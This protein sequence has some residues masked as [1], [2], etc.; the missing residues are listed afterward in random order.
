MAGVTEEQAME[1][2]A[3]QSIYLDDITLHDGARH[4]E[5]RLAGGSDNV[6]SSK[7]ALVLEVRVPADY[8]GVVPE[9]QVRSVKGVSNRTALELQLKLRD[10]AQ[11]S[12][13]APMVF[14]LTQMLKDWLEEHLD[15]EDDSA[16]SAA[17][18][19][20]KERTK[21]ALDL[22]F[23]GVGDGTPVTPENYQLWWEN[24][25]RERESL[26]PK[27][28]VEKRQTGRQYFAQSGST[29]LVAEAE[30]EAKLELAEE[31]GEVDWAL[32]EDE[33]LA[34]LDD[35]EF[36]DDEDEDEKG[37]RNKTSRLEELHYDRSEL[38]HED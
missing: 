16:L 37:T 31:S 3:M 35:E 38:E 6:S 5:V 4:Y 22:E 30:L 17:E 9:V 13:G 23:R 27:K 1:L 34:D 28:S 33:D 20:A 18:K 7:V 19:L 12:L 2:E 15:G 24:F 8:P 32:F 29:A 36:D 21:A 14:T 25:L 11:R 26:G 10:E